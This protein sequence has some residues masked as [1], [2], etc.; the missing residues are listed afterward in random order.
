MAPVRG[1]R[2]AARRRILPAFLRSS[3]KAARPPFFLRPSRAEA[4]VPVPYFGLAAPQ[5]PTD[6]AILRA[7]NRLDSTAASLCASLSVEELATTYLK[8]IRAAFPSGALP[9]GRTFLWRERR[10]RNGTPA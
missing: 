2:V 1:R 6:P 4:P 8:E 9:S 5:F 7:C 3:L 10:V